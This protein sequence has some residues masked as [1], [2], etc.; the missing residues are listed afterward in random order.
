MERNVAAG[1][2]VGAAASRI[3]AY[4]VGHRIIEPGDERWA[5]NRLLECSGQT[6]PAPRDLSWAKA[7]V[8]LDGYDFESDLSTLADAAVE[9]GAAQDSA[10]GRDRISM[11]LMGSIMARP[12]EVTRRFRSIGS[13]EG[14]LAATD[15][16]Y[17][18]CCD[19]DYVRRSAI[20]R[21][22][23][24]SC[25]TQWGDLEITINKSKPEKDPRD[26][27]AAATASVGEKYPACVLCR[28]N[29]GYGGR[30]ASDAGG[31]AARQNL[32][33]IP[34]E[35]GGEGWGFQYSPYAYFEEHCIV[36]S[37]E[38]RPM[39]VDR[40]SLGCLLDFVGQFPHYFV[41][42]NADL[43]I[44]GGSILSHDHFQGGRHVF[45]M[46]RAE[47]AEPF[48]MGAHPG[49][50]AGVLSWPLSVIRLRSADRDELLG[51]AEHVLDVWRDWDDASVGIVSH[52]ADGTRHNT[53]TPICRMKDGRFELDL[54][55]RCNV[56]TEE[57]PLGVFHPH[58]DKWHIKK[59]N[60]GLIEVMGLAILPPR[61]EREIGTVRKRIV[62][63]R[64]DGME[65]DP[66]CAPHADWAR[67]VAERRPE[68]L[69][70]SEDVSREAMRQEVGMVFCHV[71]EDAGVF[72]WDEAGR[73]ALGR[74]L[75][76]L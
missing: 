40:A 50:E 34:I 35:L 27:A 39:H 60:I 28:E 1:E 62:E 10:T 66:L 11:R 38:H 26:I 23:K 71:L 65:D 72:K 45:A 37:D 2:Q 53:V 75:A 4:A 8:L 22:L 14:A 32:R 46:T 54:A 5:Y 59:E 43:P 33:I 18:L 52:A 7:Q 74:F 56:T 67:H 73:A 51:A 58:A 69:G 55:L 3:V 6:S 48:E 15:W 31:H 19:V 25:P 61:L 70:A 24:W 16:F 13:R 76:A 41:G 29:E 49:V 63:G 21:N 12:S 57:H 68:L 44:V 36:M 47:V 30:A 64:L 17:R 42:S 20:A 9:C